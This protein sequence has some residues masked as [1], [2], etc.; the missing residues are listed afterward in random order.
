MFWQCAGILHILRLTSIFLCKAI[1]G[2]LLDLSFHTVHINREQ[3]MWINN[4]HHIDKYIKNNAINHNVQ[5][6]N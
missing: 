3:H 5:M 6:L 1:F 2:K 4:V